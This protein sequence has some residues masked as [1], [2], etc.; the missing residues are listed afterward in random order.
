M[1]YTLI[2]LTSLIIFLSLSF[3]T[4]A[5]QKSIIS[6]TS[7]SIE[8]KHGFELYED[9][10]ILY[11]DDYEIEFMEMAGSAFISQRTDY[12]N[13]EA[14]YAK[15]DLIIE[16]K[17]EGQINGYQA[18]FISLDNDPDVYQVFLGN[19]FFV[20][21]AIITTYDSIQIDE[22]FINDFL[23]TIEYNQ[24][25]N[26]SWKEKAYFEFIDE[27]SD[28]SLSKLE[29]NKFTFA[30]DNST[31]VVMIVQMKP[32]NGK[33]YLE[34]AFKTSYKKSFAKS[35]QEL[36]LI[37]EEI[38]TT[39]EFDGYKATFKVNMNESNPECIAYSFVSGNDQF[40]FMFQGINLE[41]DKAA[42]QRFEA[43]LKN[44]R[45]KE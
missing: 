16:S 31:D 26:D 12:D 11:N 36:E 42:I 29:A 25:T 20:A 7:L 24:Q 30:N 1:K 22:N 8:L 3:V 13:L 41:N 32:M 15:D 18:Y 6:G 19:G 40:T 23:G 37:E 43:F 34:D 33:L 14:I 21:I 39:D 38:L 45:F 44:I 28:W 5:Q 9:E 27:N 17:R 10:P 35:F 2:R 4:F